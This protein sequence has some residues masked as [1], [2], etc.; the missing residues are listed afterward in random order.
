MPRRVVVV[1]DDVELLELF[2]T[3]LADAGYKAV[4]CQTGAAALAYMHDAALAAVILDIRLETPDRGWHIIDAMRADPALAAIPVIA[5][6]A[7]A[8]A[9]RQ[10]DAGLHGAGYTML[11]KPF[12]LDELLS[13]VR[14][15]A[16]SPDAG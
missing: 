13:L 5:T 3:V 9:L 4:L 6:T 2:G 12:D 7:D 8:E 16:G 11:P 10:H 15:L 14:R 1:E